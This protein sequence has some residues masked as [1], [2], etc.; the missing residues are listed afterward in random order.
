VTFQ[1]GDK[2]YHV[3]GFFAADGNSAETSTDRGSQWKIRF[4]PDKI[5]MWEYTVSFRKG[6][7]IAIS[8]DP[9]EDIKGDGLAGQFEVTDINNETSD[10]SSL[11]QISIEG[12]Y[13][14]RE[15]SGTSFLKGGSDSPENFLSYVDFDQTYRFGSQA[16]NREGE[17]NPQE[18]IHKYEVHRKDWKEGKGK[19]IIGALNY[20]ASEGIHS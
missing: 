1:R 20:L 8:D 5:G 4:R 2:I 12:H 17:A 14:K 18:N 16:I 11:G 10:L 15:G 3:P 13:L 7:D 6:K 9:G 19:R